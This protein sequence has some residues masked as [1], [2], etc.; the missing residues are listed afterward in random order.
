MELEPA[1]AAFSL[2]VKPLISSVLVSETVARAEREEKGR[3]LGFGDE[4]GVMVEVALED[5]RS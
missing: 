1:A 4:E 2:D 5:V 3:C